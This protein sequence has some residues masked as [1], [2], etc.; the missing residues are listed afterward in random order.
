MSFVF[1]LPSAHLVFKSL[2]AFNSSC[3]RASYHLPRVS[4]CP[5]V[6]WRFLSGPSVLN[7]RGVRTI[8]ED[9]PCLRKYL[10]LLLNPNMFFITLLYRPGTGD[11]E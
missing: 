8:A 7:S 1:R 9:A 10:A 4:G 11:D 2:L 5:T 3:T 6:I